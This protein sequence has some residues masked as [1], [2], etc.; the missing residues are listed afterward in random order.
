MKFNKDIIVFSELR[1]T[2]EISGDVRC[3]ED[4]IEKEGLRGGEGGDAR[5]TNGSNRGL[6]TCANRDG[7]RA[8][9]GGTIVHGGGVVGDVVGGTTVHK[10]ASIIGIS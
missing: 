9:I 7:L 5:C 3:I 10:P 1:D 4:M 8:M 2:E 6:M